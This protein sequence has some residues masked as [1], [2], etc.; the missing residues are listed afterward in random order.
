MILKALRKKGVITI[1]YYQN[2]LL[3]TC[4]GRVSD[5]NLHDQTLSLEDEQH[6][7]FSIR[8]SGITDIH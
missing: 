2:G 8:L 1:N 4:K 5:L 7:I 3:Q 6:N